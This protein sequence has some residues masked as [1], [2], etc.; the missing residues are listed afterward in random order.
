MLPRPPNGVY[1]VRVRRAVAGAAWSP[2]QRFLLER[3]VLTGS[4]APL[5]VGDGQRVDTR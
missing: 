5:S 1:F 3:P 2:P 4:G